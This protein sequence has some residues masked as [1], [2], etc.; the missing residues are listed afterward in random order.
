MEFESRLHYMGISPYTN[1]PNLYP[2]MYEIRPINTLY[3]A[4][5]CKKQY[6]YFPYTDRIGN[7]EWCSPIGGIIPYTSLLHDCSF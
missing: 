1:T 7:P 6:K 5:P 3:S 4:P 2:Y